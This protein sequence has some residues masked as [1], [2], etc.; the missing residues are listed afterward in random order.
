MI[1]DEEN[2]MLTIRQT[3][4]TGILPESVLRSMQ[5]EN[6][7]PGIWVGNRFMVNCNMLLKVLDEMSENRESISSFHYKNKIK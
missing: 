6:R 3:A 1:Q 4:A 5:K 2:K 7:L